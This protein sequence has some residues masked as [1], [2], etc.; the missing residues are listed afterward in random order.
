MSTLI[1]TEVEL[2]NMALARVG[3]DKITA[4]TDSNKA[5]RQVNLHFANERDNVLRAFPWNFARRLVTLDNK[6]YASSGNL[7]FADADPDTITDSASSFVTTG[8]IIAGMRVSPED[9]SSNDSQGGYTVAT[10]A[11][12]T[13]TLVADDS[14]TAE[15]PTG[16]ITLTLRRG[17]GFDF[18]FDKP[19]DY[20]TTFEDKDSNVALPVSFLDEGDYMYSNDDVIQLPYIARVTDVSKYTSA[21]VRALYL[22]IAF[23]ICM[24]IAN[25][26]TLQADILVEYEN[27]LQ[28][29]EKQD[30]QTANPDEQPGDANFSW[31][32]NRGR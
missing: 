25:S 1:S 22:K 21:F 10:A 23:Q 29:A 13:L 11:E 2:A 26:R 28:K 20:L 31:I 9:S 18:V 6:T 30:S 27:A 4:L 17:V 8:G 19:S 14:L 24:V 7:T 16:S 12:A 3:H 32:S 5:A 15:G